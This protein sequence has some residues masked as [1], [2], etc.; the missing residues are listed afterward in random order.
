MNHSQSRSISVLGIM[1][2]AM[3]LRAPITG[4]GPLIGEISA[5]LGL[6]GAAAGA[7]VTLPLL[8]FALASLIAPALGQRLGLQRSLLASM[9]ALVAGILL[10]S[11]GGVVPLF[12]GTVIAGLAIAIS[13][14][15]LPTA[16]KRGFPDRA[17]SL[18]AAY[19]LAM[20]LMAGIASAV[21]VPLA[22]VWSWRGAAAVMFVIPLLAAL[23]CLPLAPSQAPA[24]PKAAPPSARC[25]WRSSLAWQV[26]LY[27]GFNSVV[28]YV[29]VTW[30]PAVLTDAGYSPREAGAL[31][32]LLQAVSLF[33]ALVMG[34]L[35]RRWADQ[36]GLASAAAVLSLI[37][38]AGLMVQPRWGVVWVALLGTGSG[39]GVILGLA[40]LTLRTGSAS[41]AATLSGMAQSIG[42]LLA[43]AGP[44]VA[45][46][47]REATGGWQAAL[48]LCAIQCL[49]MII[50]A[51]GAG[52][53]RQVEREGRCRA[54]WKA[55]LSCGGVER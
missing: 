21:A 39:A 16:L 20:S 5:D 32:G 8:A 28:F 26:A 53:I 23:A 34:P 35:L 17:A 46:A 48:G 50:L 45:G 2:I 52:R 1:L 10:R 33:P 27:M 14:V 15:L 44:V 47:L 19:V 24:G 4:M 42:Y 38:V 11:S 30:L 25:V 36:R 55:S 22:L 49:A 41:L 12:A 51:Q 3:S 40:F 31:H 7:L 29:C 37:G 54:V 18:T 6:T 43:A 13:N 9:A